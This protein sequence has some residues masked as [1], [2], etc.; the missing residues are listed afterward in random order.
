MATINATVATLLD[1]AKR[2]DPDGKIAKIAELLSQSN[3][4]LLDCQYKEGNLPTGHRST[5][6][7]ALPGVGFRRL[8]AG[9]LPTKSRTG[10]TEDATAILEAW[11]QCDL[12][13]AELNGNSAEF[14]MSENIAFI[15]AMAQEMQGTMLYGNGGTDPEEFDGFMTRYASTSAV[16]GQ[17]V[18]LGGG[19]G[20]DNSSILLV[21]WGE[22]VHGIY[23]KG[24]K[25]GLSHVDH[26]TQVIQNAGGVT[27]ALMAAYMDQY[28]W[29]GGLHVR[30]WRYAVRIANIDISLL[31]A[32][33]GTTEADLT[34]LMIKAWHRIPSWVGVR[35]AWY[36][37]RT[38]A[39]MLDVQR[40][41]QVTAGGGLSYANVDGQWV[42]TFRGLPIRTCDQMIEAEALVS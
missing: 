42:N 5:I 29:E 38:V 39:Q 6:R 31:V 15:E 28:T 8:N 30:D 13:V 10:Q 23:P 14:R 32:N 1:H 22:N 7:T 21:C 20:A 2:L 40:R 41:D 18:L 11:A 34:L 19:A 24:S 35:G 12:K 36:V 25:A 9:T 33:A 3:E 37:N 16:N 4:M 26:G 27:G 17:N